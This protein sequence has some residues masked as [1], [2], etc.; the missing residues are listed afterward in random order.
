V[1]RREPG[2]LAHAVIA[3]G[4]VW[5]RGR[6]FTSPAARCF[7]LLACAVLAGCE[8]KD[9]RSPNNAA[10]TITAQASGNADAASCAVLPDT[11]VELL[12]A[13]RD[14]NDLPIT[15]IELDANCPRA[16]VLMTAGA[17]IQRSYRVTV[18]AGRWLVA[19]ARAED[20]PVTIAFDYPAA[21]RGDGRELTRVALDSIRITD[22]RDVT[23]RVML[24]PRVKEDPRGSRVL[25]TVLVRP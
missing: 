5:P 19:R 2:E 25:L 3:A 6:G 21:V 16:T 8:A 23:V 17:R 15:R 4:L 14:Q 9:A 18:P 13:R 24:V 12:S 22:T 11:M 7:V 1:G 10:R 20:A